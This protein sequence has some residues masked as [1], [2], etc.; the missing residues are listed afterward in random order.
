MKKEIAEEEPLPSSTKTPKK[1]SKAPKA[2]QHSSS[3]SSE[4]EDLDFGD[5]GEEF[6]DDEENDLEYGPPSGITKNRQK[7][8]KYELEEDE[9]DDGLNLAG[10]EIFHKIKT[11]EGESWF[12]QNSEED[13]EDEDLSDE[14]AS[15]YF[16]EGFRGSTNK[17]DEK[18]TGLK[19]DN[20][21]I[22]SKKGGQLAPMKRNIDQVE[23]VVNEQIGATKRVKK[24][25]ILKEEMVIKELRKNKK[26]LYIVF[27]YI[28]YI[29]FP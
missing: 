11:H 6:S 29:G 15:D 27:I 23:G 13:G 16:G 28:I 5:A 24:D 8:G 9:R 3:V 2:Q 12:N 17:E 22:N 26:I 14:E 20:L 7:R 25:D 4:H 10:K 18:E 1:T 19:K 21:I